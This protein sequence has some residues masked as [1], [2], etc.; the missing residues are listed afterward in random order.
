MDWKRFFLKRKWDLVFVL[1]LAY[2]IFV[3]H[4]PVRLFLTNLVGKARTQIEGIVLNKNEQLQ[5]DEK[6]WNWVI[7]DTKGQIHRFDEFKGKPILINFWS[8]SCPPC[9]AELPSLAALYQS[10]NDKMSFLFVSLDSPSQA[11]Q[12]TQQRHLEIPIYFRASNTPPIF[13]TQYIPTT[14]IID[15]SGIMRVKKTGALNWN[16]NRIKRLLEQWGAK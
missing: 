3:P 9:V 13:R 16:S 15:S 1:F 7:T 12:F 14:I 5:L 8:V 2:M 4:N 10:Y 6:V 11:L